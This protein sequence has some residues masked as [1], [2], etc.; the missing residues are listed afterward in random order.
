MDG[1]R[2]AF[3]L[4]VRRLA[5]SARLATLARLGTDG[6]FFGLMP[7]AIAA[8]LSGTVT[9]P[10]APLAVAGIFAAAG[11]LIGCALALLR[12]QDR[13]GLLIQ[14]DRRLGARELASTALELVERRATGPF[15]QAVIEDASGLLARSTRR[16]ALGR[17]R[18]PLLPWVPALLAIIALALVFP[19]N[20]TSLF[21]RPPSAQG[22]LQMIGEDLQSYGQKLR[23]A[24][25]AQ[26]LPNSLALSQQLAQL[27]K[28]LADKKIQKDE[29]LDR[30]SELER[31]LAQEYDLRLPGEQGSAQGQ[32]TGTDTGKQGDATDKGNA[33]TEGAPGAAGQSESGSSSDRELKDLGDALHKLRDAQQRAERAG[34]E[35]QGDESS[36]A[37]QPPSGGQGQKSPTP[38]GAGAG[39][40]P[41]SGSGQGQGQTGGGSGPGDQQQNDQGDAGSAAGTAPAP[42]K[43]GVPTSITQGSRTAPLRAGGAPGEGDYTKLLVRALPEWSGSHVPE[44]KVFRQYAQ[45]VESALSRDEIPPKLKQYV[46]D[47]FTIIGMSAGDQHQ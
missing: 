23:D 28:D 20:L 1:G 25:S 2:G 47:Y 27:G 38:P 14:A 41:G 36:L 39:K 4:H 32:G 46:R 31:H 19:V 16:Q 3:R 33:G 13:R 12:R 26:N 44:E 35:G 17:L 45:Q 34:P 42:E 29:A 7:G 11:L 18:L 8:A 30:M 43:T 21:T 15:P 5:L 40:S 37:Q 22:E 6:L 10:L 24:A 9:L